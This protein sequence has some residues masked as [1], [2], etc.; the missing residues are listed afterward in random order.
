MSQ[1]KLTSALLLEI[2]L[3]KEADF[4][5]TFITKLGGFMAITFCGETIT[6][7]SIPDWLALVAAVGNGRFGLVYKN[8]SLEYR[9]IASHEH[10]ACVE[11]V[12]RSVELENKN[13]QSRIIHSNDAHKLFE[14]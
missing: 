9:V 14:I 4:S 7:S 3:K 6:G 1:K 12:K 13:L 11:S 5:L 2:L 8:D 10:E